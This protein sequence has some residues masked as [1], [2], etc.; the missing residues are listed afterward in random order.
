[1]PLRLLNFEAFYTR[2]RLHCDELIDPKGDPPHRIRLPI[3]QQGSHAFNMNHGTYNKGPAA[4]R[5]TLQR[6]VSPRFA[7]V[8]ICAANGA[9]GLGGTLNCQKLN[10]RDLAHIRQVAL[11][12]V[13]AKMIRIPSLAPSFSRVFPIFALSRGSFGAISQNRYSLSTHRV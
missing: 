9:K 1:M 10:Q 8:P 7:F 2:D 13:L 5:L 6:L 4:V 11:L 3:P 12:Q